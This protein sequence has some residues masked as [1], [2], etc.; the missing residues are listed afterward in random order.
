MAL[1]KCTECG[2]EFSDKAAMCPNCGCPTEAI[3][4][5]LNRAAAKSQIKVIDTY[6]I[7]GKEFVMDEPHDRYIRLLTALEHKWEEYGGEILYYFYSIKEFDELLSVFPEKI[8]LV[9][10][11]FLDDAVS[12][13]IAAGIYDCDKR[14]FYEKHRKIFNHSGWVMSEVIR[15]YLKKL[16]YVN[17]SD[18]E[19][20]FDFHWSRYAC[21]SVTWN[22]EP[23]VKTVFEYQMNYA[24]SYYLSTRIHDESHW[25]STK[26][27]QRADWSD[28]QSILEDESLPNAILSR[29]WDIY[30]DCRDALIQDLKE[31]GYLSDEGYDLDK[32]KSIL[33]NAEAAA[34]SQ[35]I[36]M[37]KELYLQ[38]FFLA[39]YDQKVVTL[40]LMWRMDE[41]GDVERYA[42]EYGFYEAYKKE[43]DATMQ[44]QCQIEAQR[45]EKD[46]A[47]GVTTNALFL[48]MMTRCNIFLLGGVNG[49]DYIR[50]A[51][52]QRTGFPMTEEEIKEIQKL[53]DSWEAD[54]FY[55]DGLIS[56]VRG[57]LKLAD[58]TE[59][60]KI[61]AIVQQ[62]CSAYSHRLKAQT[63]LFG[64]KEDIREKGSVKELLLK[65]KVPERAKLFLLYDRSY[66]TAE[67]KY[68]YKVAVLTDLGFFSYVTGK[69]S[70][71]ALPWK[72]VA[73]NGLG[74]VTDQGLRIGGEILPMT[75]INNLYVILRDI[76]IRVRRSL[77][78]EKAEDIPA[79][80]KTR[81]A[82]TDRIQEVCK[83]YYPQ[84]S[85]QHWFGSSARIWT[86][87]RYQKVTERLGLPSDSKVFYQYSGVKEYP[88]AFDRQLILSNYGVFWGNGSDQKNTYHVS[89][90]EFRDCT[91]IA[92]IAKKEGLPD[93]GY[94]E[95]N[96]E[97]FYAGEDMQ[98][99]DNLLYDIKNVLKE[100]TKEI[101]DTQFR[102]LPDLNYRKLF[103]KYDSVDV[104]DEQD[105]DLVEKAYQL[106]PHFKETVEELCAQDQNGIG[107]PYCLLWLKGMQKAILI[108]DE[109]LISRHEAGSYIAP[110]DSVI[111]LK[112]GRDPDNN[113]VL[114]AYVDDDSK[115]ILETWVAITEELLDLDLTP[116]NE[117]IYEKTPF[118]HATYFR[119]GWV[120]DKD[121]QKAIYLYKLAA[122]SERLEYKSCMHLAELYT[123]IQSFLLANEAYLR[124]AGC[125][126]ANKNE[127]YY[128]RALLIYDHREVRFGKRD[129]AEVLQCM[130]EAAQAK[131]MDAREKLAMILSDEV[132]M[133]RA[134]NEMENGLLTDI[135]NRKGRTSAEYMMDKTKE[136]VAQ[137][138]NKVFSFLKNQKK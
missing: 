17:P 79:T 93:P 113:P 4:E 94:L 107:E 121:Y 16:G 22:S 131:Y 58:Q 28:K 96:G 32:E 91:L 11:K 45:I 111:T 46:L 31:A 82:I 10:E 86:N 122:I 63:F 115:Q 72:Q 80:W 1:I 101:D 89:W 48:D 8:A 84:E 36:E 15:R 136:G 76:R 103:E 40:I 19:T 60:E 3:L 39:P 116:L 134:Q 88:D 33:T 20:E 129:S 112:T 125:E 52:D 73:E 30:T 26:R 97:K 49:T 18:Y 65:A 118:N 47:D 44:E 38:A 87:G 29:M 42:R 117:W 75:D 109:Y 70:T 105:G 78:M 130:D 67:N 6:Q 56:Y 37:L 104:Y 77:G 106:D 108:T 27:K 21:H 98:F 57:A 83:K 69:K 114:F 66:K 110:F 119:L 9:E 64:N 35:D 135:I 13:L 68:V 102:G 132:W 120:V 128:K 74:F 51:I 55:G 34:K 53:A 138:K 50:R 123:A 25:I 54:K 61:A 12:Q 124:A 133:A 100:T 90:L 14:R 59:F 126:N 137:V 2:K 92:G 41:S 85:P 7:L 24:G 62:T 43:W 81:R 95:I 5:E 71:G 127:I 99:I 23:D